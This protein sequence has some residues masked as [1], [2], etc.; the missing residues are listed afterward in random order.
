MTWHV[1]R[2]VDTDP[3][4]CGSIPS[5]ITYSSYDYCFGPYSTQLSSHTYYTIPTC[6]TG[7]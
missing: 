1:F 4:A 7:E 3:S 2:R 6:V 5:Y